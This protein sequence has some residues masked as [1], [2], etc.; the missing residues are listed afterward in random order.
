MINF[1]KI[2]TELEQDLIGRQK[3]LALSSALKIFYG[4][5]SE[6]HYRI[7]FLSTII[8]PKFGSTKT[9][10]IYQGQ[11]SENVYWTCLDLV[12]HHAK[13]VFYSLCNDLVDAIVD[14]E[15][16]ENA[17]VL[18]KNRY[19]A[20]R[21]MFKKSKAS[22]TEERVK[23]LFGEMYFLLNYMTP[24]YGIDVAINSWSG[25]DGASK[26]FSK[27]MDWYEV[28]T[29]S[30]TATTVKISSI[31]QL[32]S[33]TKGYLTIIKLEK[34]SDEYRDGQSSISELFTNILQNIKTDG[35]KEK[36]IAK[37]VAYGFDISDEN[38]KLNFKTIDMQMYI[39]DENFPRLKETDIKFQEITKMTYE[40]IINTLDKYKVEE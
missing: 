15:S 27:D 31:S 38:I 32:S 40:L 17:L 36:F 16:E 28:K 11:E 23:G 37:L 5:N 26:D 33:N 25:P 21:L 9:L 18:L 6:G 12:D 10:K 24:K 8:P 20:W 2:Y 30:S 34:M 7:A 19:F 14:E 35:L 3:K 1:E 4:I 22:I 29:T 13:Q 39:V